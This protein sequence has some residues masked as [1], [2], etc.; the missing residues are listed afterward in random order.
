M[1]TSKCASRHN[2]LQFFIFQGH[3]MVQKFLYR[4]V[5]A[6]G[7]VKS[8]CSEFSL[9]SPKIQNVFEV[10]WAPYSLLSTNLSRP[11]M[12]THWA[13]GLNVVQSPKVFDTLFEFSAF[14]VFFANFR[15]FCANFGPNRF[16]NLVRGTLEALHVAKEGGK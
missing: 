6:R 2:G 8:L 3:L 1:F 5:S 4:K 16:C 12:P 11:M 7:M 15:L 14:C 10:F 9:V 13:H